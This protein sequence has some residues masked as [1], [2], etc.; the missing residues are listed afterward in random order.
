MGLGSWVPEIMSK[1]C[2]NFS[3]EEGFIFI[4]FL[5]SLLLEKVKIKNLCMGY[6]KHLSKKQVATYSDT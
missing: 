6:A 2:M 3:E 5:K 1:I 4:I